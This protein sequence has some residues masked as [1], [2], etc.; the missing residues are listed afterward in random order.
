MPCTFTGSLEGDRALAYQEHADDLAKQITKLTQLLCKTLT[1]V[2]AHDGLEY[3][4]K[5]VNKWWVS[6]KKVDARR[7]A[8]EKK[9][10]EKAA[11]ND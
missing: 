2:E 5:D 1:I 9:A 8:R 11:N 10:A 7:L 4:P 6:H 3:L